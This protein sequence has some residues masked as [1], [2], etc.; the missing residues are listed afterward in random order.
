MAFLVFELLEGATLRTVLDRGRM[1][2]AKDVGVGIQ[3]AQGLA[4]TQEKGIV[5][6]DLK[7]ENLFLAKGDQVKI[8]DFGLAKL[9]Q[10]EIA[11]R[12]EPD[13]TTLAGSLTTAGT[14]IGTPSCGIVL[15]AALSTDPDRLRRFEQETRS[16]AAVS[17]CRA[18]NGQT[19][20]LVCRRSALNPGES[21]AIIKPLA[22]LPAGAA[23]VFSR[24][25]SASL[26]GPP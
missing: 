21:K 5:H 17:G 8:L 19:G 14:V 25:V 4:A 26:R 24:L 22:A 18:N 13:V 2:Q 9:R 10:T 23:A 1:P 15:P 20:L 7:P 12:I 6:R 16:V 3:I 11:T